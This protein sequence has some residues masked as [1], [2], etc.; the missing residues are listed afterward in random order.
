MGV[1]PLAAICSVSGQGPSKPFGPIRLVV[2]EPSLP[3]LS[4]G[5]WRR[6]RLIDASSGGR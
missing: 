5:S 4:N 6:G 3:M 2:S 1:K